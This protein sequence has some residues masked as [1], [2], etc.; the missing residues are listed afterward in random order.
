MAT[1]VSFSQ[2][3]RSTV[4]WTSTVS[5]ILAMLAGFYVMLSINRSI[6][7]ERAQVL[8]N[9]T[10]ANAQAAVSLRDPDR[11]R[12]LLATFASAKSVLAAR[13]MDSAN[14]AFVEY[15]KSGVSVDPTL[16]SKASDN[17]KLARAP[18]EYGGENLG[19]VEVVVDA[20]L[21]QEFS[22]FMLLAT[23]GV[24]SL[25]LA[26]IWLLARP[27]EARISKPITALS[28]FT[29]RIRDSKDYALRIPLSPVKELRGLTEDLNDMLGVIERAHSEQAQRSTEL[30]KLAFYDQL[31]GAANRSLFRDR[32]SQCVNDYNRSRRPFSLIGIDL[33][34]FKQLNDNHGHA[35]G[36]DYLREVAARC[37]AALR[38]ADTFARMGGD[39]FVVLLPAV[40]RQSDALAV[41]Q[42]LSA[43]VRDANKIHQKDTI[44]TA[45]IGVGLFPFDAPTP[46]ELI[47]KV[48]AAMYRA[49][50]NGR[51]QIVPVT[52]TVH[53]PIDRPQPNQAEFNRFPN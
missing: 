9:I 34:K 37:I 46:T 25:V 33:D 43:A 8:A 14:N 41:A 12:E 31:T 2:Q 47:A 4:V 7:V 53:P 45:S 44:C 49:K 30:S 3:I 5:I 22:K 17:I 52:E 18:I 1:V 10:A 11:G 32:L 39:E 28:H 24:V 36:D 50:S 27:I 16:F 15:A 19:S 38:P 26:G 20:D 48:D 23:V 51:D 35:V 21:L 40:D 13:V 6:A 29:R 42:K